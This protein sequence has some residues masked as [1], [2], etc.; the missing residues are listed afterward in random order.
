MSGRRTPAWH[1]TDL[2]TILGVVVRAG[3]MP[4]VDYAQYHFLFPLFLGRDFSEA[5][6]LALMPG[7]VAF[8][9]ILPIYGVSI[10]YIIAKTAGK[11]LRIGPAL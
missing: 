11:N 5:F 10:G 8:N 7:I 2:T 1:P 4:F 6:I 3:I 9:I